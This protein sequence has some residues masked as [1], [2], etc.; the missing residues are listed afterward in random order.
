LAEQPGVTGSYL[1]GWFFVPEKVLLLGLC[2]VA[3]SAHQAVADKQ[4]IEDSKL[5]LFAEKDVTDAVKPSGISFC[6][7]RYPMAPATSLLPTN[8]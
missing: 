7:S 1:E 6:N 5:L 2:G 8:K 4:G 3:I